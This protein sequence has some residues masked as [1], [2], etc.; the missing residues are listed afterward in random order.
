MQGAR[1]AATEPV[2]ESTARKR[3]PRNAADGRRS[4]FAACCLLWLPPLL[5][6]S[7]DAHAWGL[8]THVYFAQW[9]LWTLPL[10]DPNLRRAVQKFPELVMA[11]A[12]L[13]DLA[14]VSPIFRGTH[15]W[16]HVHLMLNGARCDEETAI[17]IG[18]ASHLLADV[19]AHNHFVPAHE[20]MWLDQGMLTHITSEWAMDAHLASLLAQRPHRL[21]LD[22]KQRL[23]SLMARTFR[24]APRRAEQALNR[25][26]QA[27]RLLRT[28]RLPQLLY[29][30]FRR[31]D[32]RVFRHFVYYISQTQAVLHDMESVLDG[33]YPFWEP[34]PAHPQ[35]TLT[36]LRRFSL[37]QLQNRHPA[38]LGLFSPQPVYTSRKDSAA[39]EAPMAAPAST[40]LG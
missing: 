9:L 40:S 29:A 10:A 33:A 19:V 31:A 6:Q 5:L 30:V 20:A 1:S 21:L 15:R 39:I 3:A 11:G 32:R 16:E 26:A 2:R 13:P 27:D 37:L 38:P 34:D 14:L 35:T 17:A 24:C 4:S 25:L 36:Q 28:V 12:C 22:H 18:Y 8:L 7:A 23:G